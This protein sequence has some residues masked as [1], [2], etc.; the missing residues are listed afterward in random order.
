MKSKEKKQTKTVCSACQGSGNCPRCKGT[1]K[2]PDPIKASLPCRRC[3]GTGICSGC[4]GS[5]VVNG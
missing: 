2:D 5:G 1:G 3:N 4:H